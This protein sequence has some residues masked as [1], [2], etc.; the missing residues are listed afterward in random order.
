MTNAGR[1]SAADVRM[2]GCAHHGMD[3]LQYENRCD[4]FRHNY[5]ERIELMARTV[6]AGSAPVP[7]GVSSGPRTAP[8]DDRSTSSP[9]A[10]LPRKGDGCPTSNEGRQLDHRAAARTG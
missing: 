2:G 6:G 1:A 9:P 7:V 10:R 5:E 8:A 3:V 4:T